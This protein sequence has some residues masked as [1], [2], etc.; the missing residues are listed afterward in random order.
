MVYQASQTNQR[1]LPGHLELAVQLT[2]CPSTMKWQ[3]T[4]MIFPHFPKFLDCRP[5]QATIQR[6]TLATTKMTMTT[7][8][9]ILTTL[10][11]ASKTCE[12]KICD[13]RTFRFIFPSN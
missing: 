12:S 7:L 8:A 9:T 4:T 5:F 2:Q 11:L 3:I 1:R 13:F 10:K 6:R